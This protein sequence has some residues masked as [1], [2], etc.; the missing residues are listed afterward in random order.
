MLLF[1]TTI[2]LRFTDEQRRISD[3]IFHPFLPIKSV[4]F[5][6]KLT[7]S[8]SYLF[9][10]SYYFPMKTL[11]RSFFCALTAAF[12]L[13]SINPFG[14]S[15]LVMFYVTYNRPWFLFELLPFILLGVF[16]GLFGAAFIHANLAWCKFRANSKV[17]FKLNSV[18]LMM[19]LAG[20]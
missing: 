1:S 16:G 2:Y 7:R 15:H 13:R 5:L 12:I 8:S 11:W 9:K 6:L 10:V 14:N 3:L 19:C 4:T 20:F 18:C 17:G